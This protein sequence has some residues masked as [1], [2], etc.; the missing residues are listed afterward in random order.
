MYEHVGGRNLRIAGPQRR[1]E[2]N[3]HLDGDRTRDAHARHW[4]IPQG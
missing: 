4:F 1:R 2:D 3:H